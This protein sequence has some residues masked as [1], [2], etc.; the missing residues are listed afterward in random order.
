M[1][2]STVL[3][4]GTDG[5]TLTLSLCVYTYI[6]I[7]THTYTHFFAIIYSKCLHVSVY[8]TTKVVAVVFVLFQKV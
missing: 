8:I 2:L 4:S 3:S 5:W 6:Y 1:N 7:Y